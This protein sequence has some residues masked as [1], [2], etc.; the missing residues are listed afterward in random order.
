MERN[1]FS[2]HPSKPFL[3]FSKS[4]LPLNIL[5]VATFLASFYRAVGKK[6]SLPI[7]EG[8]DEQDATTILR[9]NDLR[10]L[11]SK[12]DVHRNKLEN[13][14]ASGSDG[15]KVPFDSRVVETK[16]GKV[17]GGCS[18][19]AC[20]WLNVPF[21]EPFS[22]R[23]EA[24]RVRKTPYIAEGVGSATKYG[25]ACIQNFRV[26][27]VGRQSEDCM[28][29]NI[30][31]PSGYAD[32]KPLPVMIWIYGGA[33]L[34]G[35]AGVDYSGLTFN[36]TRLAMHGVLVVTLQYRVGIF[37][38][39]QQPDGTGGANGFGDMINALKW[40]QLHI[41]SF[42]G[43]A[44][45]VTLFGESAGSVSVCTLS[46][47]PAARGLFHRVIAESGSCYPSGDIILN[48]SEATG[49]RARYLRL[50]GIPEHELLTMNAQLLVNLTLLAIVPNAKK[51]PDPFTPFF[52][53]G[54][55]QPSVDSNILPDSPWRLPT[56]SGLDLLHGYNSGEVRMGPPGGRFPGNALAYFGKYLGRK[57]ASLILAQYGPDYEQ[58]DPS[59]I[60]ADACLRCNTIRYA[61]RVASSQNREQLKAQV[62]LYVYN[63]PPNASFHGADVAAVFGTTNGSWTSPDGSVNTS[64]A[65]VHKIQN[66]WTS[67]AKG[68]DISKL[69]HNMEWPD[70]PKLGRD[71]GLVHAMQLGERNQELNITNSRCQKWIAAT[72]VIGGWKTARMCSD[73][74]Q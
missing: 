74:Y 23:F 25:P 9:R 6:A 51:I 49:V 54:V 32:M 59:Y 63:N 67:F 43:D 5:V 14:V 34:T 1:A 19:A 44:E 36:G 56:H 46:H 27:N 53:S 69:V 47:L 10:I 15:F 71:H 33:F 4:K 17:H 8:T 18:H 45:Q 28:N 40:V 55:G 16:L 73:F 62:R 13:F 39:L 48:K 65:L 2:K 24:S 61:Q 60:V 58:I 7:S 72:H 31:A 68:E 50:L 35:S 26:G 52:I 38:F 22:H 20:Q 64:E 21:A 29:L 12:H 30:F 3:P 66:I 11:N 42:N 57:I 70:V 37:G 41:T